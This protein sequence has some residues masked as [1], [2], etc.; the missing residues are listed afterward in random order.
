MDKT[1]NES[2]QAPALKKIDLMQLE[3]LKLNTL[4]YLQTKQI[5]KEAR[6]SQVPLG[7]TSTFRT[8]A[9]QTQLR[10][11]NCPDPKNSPAESCTPATEK[12]GQSLHNYG[13]ALDFKCDGYPIFS[14]SPCYTW[15][16]QNTQTFK[17]KRHTSEPWHWSF[18]SK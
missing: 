1:P 3:G 8:C 18:T 17:L 13:M 10:Q 16:T 4:I 9:E 11:A 14:S 2:C 7:L 12:P 5:L 15:L 6:A